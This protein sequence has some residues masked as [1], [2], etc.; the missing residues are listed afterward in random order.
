M[1][2]KKLRYASFRL[3]RVLIPTS[4]SIFSSSSTQTRLFLGAAVFCDVPGPGPSA[5]GN[6]TRAQNFFS[7]R[8]E[9]LVGILKAGNVMQVEIFIV[10]HM[11]Q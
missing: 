7:I 10:S 2:S 3:P 5:G 9:L 6:L 4:I 1:V 11:H 8:R